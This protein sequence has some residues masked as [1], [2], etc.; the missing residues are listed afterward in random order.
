V[1]QFAEIGVVL[2]LFLVGLELEPRRC[3]RCAVRSS[4]WAPRKSW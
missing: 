2:L 3:G 1:L 4:A